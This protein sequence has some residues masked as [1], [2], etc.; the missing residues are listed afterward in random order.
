MISLQATIL[1]EDTRDV[2]HIFCT[3]ISKSFDVF[4]VVTDDLWDTLELCFP[5]RKNFTLMQT[6]A[7]VGTE[8]MA[9]KFTIF[10]LSVAG[11]RFRGAAAAL[12]LKGSIPLAFAQSWHSHPGGG[13]AAIVSRVFSQKNVSLIL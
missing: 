7:R 3:D 11:L 2:I 4:Y 12:R 8:G 1:G 13:T 10:R 5:R 6:L 9:S